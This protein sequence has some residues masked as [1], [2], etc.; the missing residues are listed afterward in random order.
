ML[1]TIRQFA[2]EQLAA[3]G[4]ATEART[5]HA[6]YFAGREADIMALWDSP[7]QRAAYDWFSLELANLRTAFRWAADYGD[8]DSAAAIA[9]YVTFLG[10]W[11]EQYEPVAWAEELIEPAHA[12]DHRRLAQLY[13]MAAQCYRDERIEDALDY[14]EAGQLLIESRRYDEVR[15]EYQALLGAL[16]VTKGE[17]EWFV[18]LC[19]NM[20]AR[21]SGPQNSMRA[22]QAMALKVAGADDEAMAASEGLLA[23]ATAAKNP[24]VVAWS[25]LAY[26]FAYSDA[27]PI[28][29]YEALR[30]GLRIA[31]E[32]GNRQFVSI[33]AVNLSRPAATQGDP[34]DAFDFLTLAIRNYHDAGN[35][36]LMPMPS[37][38]LAAF[39][40]RLGHHEPAA[41]ISRFAATPSTRT[42]FPEINATITHLRDVLGETT[43][44]SLARKGE[45]MTTAAMVTYAFDQIDQAE[46]N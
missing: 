20:I 13:L 29:A 37:A 17:P 18:A 1:E 32:S 21:S 23:D 19:R 39:F 30:Q 12:V 42:A 10:I 43:Y 38:V 14:S 40:D 31:Q 8:L 25:L 27:N 7:R 46:Q 6:R 9:S 2:E 3:S 35:L 44:E 34:L 33:I 24:A 11:V 36:S 22:L 45:T 16:Y 4:A 28:A 41:T 5:A 26:G 15:A